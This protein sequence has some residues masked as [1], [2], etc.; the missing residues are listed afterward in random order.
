[1]QLSRKLSALIRTL[2]LSVVPI[3]FASLTL[4]AAPIDDLLLATCSA[5]NLTHAHP[6]SCVSATSEGHA[7]DFV[8][9][10]S[11]GFMVG[12]YVNGVT[13]TSGTEGG[14]FS[15][16]A[17]VPISVRIDGP[18][19]NIVVYSDSTQHQVLA[20]SPG[21]IGNV[22]YK[23]GP[24]TII[25]RHPDGGDPVSFEFEYTA[26]TN[27][28][29]WTT[30]E[31]LSRQ[32]GASMGL[33]ASITTGDLF[34]SMDLDNTYRFY[35]ADGVTPVSVTISQTP[36]PGSLLLLLSAVPFVLLKARRRRSVNDHV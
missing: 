1:M 5:E 12:A 6:S 36:E 21:T 29:V 16:Y 14:T 18:S 35:E 9:S 30:D 4:S 17:E 25:S 13:W 7:T 8:Q 24:S 27:M 20:T 23:L 10:F 34:A 22:S 33:F 2:K 11:N 32:F 19:R 26:P 15:L 28:E 31:L 3:A